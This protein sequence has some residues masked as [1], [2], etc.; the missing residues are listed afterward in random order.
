MSTYAFLVQRFNPDFCSMLRM[1]MVCMAYSISVI[2]EHTVDH[3]MINHSVFGGYMF[4]KQKI[5]RKVMYSLIPVYLFS[6]YLYGWRVLA[7]SLVVLFCGVLAEYIMTKRR[8]KKVSEAVF[9]T[10]FL[11]ILSLP[12]TT[13][14]WIAA[15]GIVFGV[16]IVKEAFGGFGRNIFNPAIGGRLFIYITF[17]S[18]LALSW[19]IPGAFGQSGVLAVD[20][21]SAATPLQEFRQG[22]IPEFSNLL[23]GFRSGSIGESSI[24]LILAAAIYLIVTKTANWRLMLSTLVTGYLLSFIFITTGLVPGIDPS[25]YTFMQELYIALLFIMSGSFFFCLVFM[26]TDPVTAPNKAPAQFIY[27]ALIAV[28][29]ILIRTFSLFPEGTS[30]AIIV[31]NTFASFLDEIM[32]KKKKAA[33]KKSPAKTAKEAS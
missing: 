4:Q 28:I 17:P 16:I 15:V 14:L 7:I 13:P 11:F 24:L 18:I 27:G 10:C 25:A 2:L 3:Y 30:F 29:T 12:P 21:I 33:S 9:V 20:A 22:I 26:C 1:R 6:V 23:F 32:P 8:N 5:M 19:M 31:G